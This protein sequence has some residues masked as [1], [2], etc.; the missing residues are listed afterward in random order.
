MILK[1]ILFR[2]CL[3]RNQQKVCLVIFTVPSLTAICNNCLIYIIYTDVLFIPT[4]LNDKIRTQLIPIVFCRRII[5][6]VIDLY[7][8]YTASEKLKCKFYHFVK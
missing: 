5:V 8:K 3:L 4:L 2:K 1:A 7:E 6:I